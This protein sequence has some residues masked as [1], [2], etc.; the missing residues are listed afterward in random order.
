LILSTIVSY[1]DSILVIY[2]QHR[3]WNLSAV[4]LKNCHDIRGDINSFTHDHSQILEILYRWRR[5][6]GLAFVSKRDLQVCNSAAKRGLSK[7]SV[8]YCGFFQINCKTLF[9]I[10]F[11]RKHNALTSRFACYF[12]GI[13]RLHISFLCHFGLHTGL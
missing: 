12:Y 3:T 1:R 11:R 13:T 2:S 8:I 5:Y 9:S 7:F 10:V 4:L 6:N